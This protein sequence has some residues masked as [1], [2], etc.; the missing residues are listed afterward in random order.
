MN[1]S[2]EVKYENDAKDFFVV[3]VMLDN[4]TIFGVA[5]KTLTRGV[6]IEAPKN[7][8]GFPTCKLSRDVEEEILNILNI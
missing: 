5:V 3:N 4:V 8:K 1:V 2:V 7:K 6:S